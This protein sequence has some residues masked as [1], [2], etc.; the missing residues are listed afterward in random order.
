MEALIW[1]MKCTKNLRQFQVTYLED[2]K[3]LR[4]SF[5]NSEIIHVPR[6]ANLK[7]DSLAHSA[8]KQPSFVI[9][10]DPEL[11]FLVTEST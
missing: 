3:L 8:R 7:V 1:A 11:P 5:L 4:R 9:H 2:I 10:M 6:T